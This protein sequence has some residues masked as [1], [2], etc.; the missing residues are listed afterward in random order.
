MRLEHFGTLRTH[1]SHELRAIVIWRLNSYF[2]NNF[3]AI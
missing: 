2:K 3:A 1:V